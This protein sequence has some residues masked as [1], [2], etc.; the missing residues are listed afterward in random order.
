[1]GLLRLSSSCWSSQNPG[2]VPHTSTRISEGRSS[3]CLHSLIQFSRPWGLV[4]VCWEGQE[5]VACWQREGGSA[6]GLPEGLGRVSAPSLCPLS[7]F[8][9]KK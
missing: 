4:A 9:V 5:C 8:F 1:M 7:S 2:E 3:L 6:Q